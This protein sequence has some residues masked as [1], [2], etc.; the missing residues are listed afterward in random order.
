MVPY[1]LLETTAD[2]FWSNAIKSAGIQ[3]IVAARF[4]FQFY[5]R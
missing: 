2:V 1:D 5:G 3:L 4:L